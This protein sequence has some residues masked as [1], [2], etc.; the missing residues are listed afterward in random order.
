M[1]GRPVQAPGSRSSVVV[2]GA[3]D[4]G[5]QRK[6]RAEAERLTLAIELAR[7]EARLRNE[8]W[9]LVV[10][11]GSYR[12]WR[13]DEALGQWHDVE[14]HEFN[15]DATENGIEFAVGSQSES[16]ADGTDLSWPADAGS[17]DAA[18]VPGDRQ[19]G[20]EVVIYPSGE[21][22]PFEVLVSGARTYAPWVVRSDG[23]QR[24]GAF[25]ETEAAEAGEV[26]D[27]LSQW[28]LDN[29]LIQ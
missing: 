3:T 2:L 19:P 18:G 5:H 29:G 28:L 6:I 12:F 21:L 27:G 11:G 23:I 14:R 13:Y 17:F 15:A 25:A 7:D 9:G 10:D 8:I 26:D 1:P 4:V 16:S 22:T 20:P 24:A